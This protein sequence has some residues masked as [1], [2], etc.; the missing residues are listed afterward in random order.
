MSL[1]N[2]VGDLL[3]LLGVVHEVV[4]AVRVLVVRVAGVIRS[5]EDRILRN[6]L[7]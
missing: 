4:F 1:L 6:G 5:L 2:V 3:G 7:T